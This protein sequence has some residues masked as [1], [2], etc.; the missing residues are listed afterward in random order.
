MTPEIFS[1][2]VGLFM[3]YVVEFMKA[4]LPETKGK[5][6]GYSLS[7]LVSIIIGGTGSYLGGSFDTTNILSS[8]GSSLIASQGV[9]SL[10]FKPSGTDEKVNNKFK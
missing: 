10:W 5:W 3:P 2:F 1:G 4:K 7:L 9:Y 6:L 8:V